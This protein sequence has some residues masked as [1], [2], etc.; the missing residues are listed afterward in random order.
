MYI[1]VNDV[2]M[3]FDKIEKKK[4]LIF[5]TRCNFVMACCEKNMIFDSMTQN[6]IWKMSYDDV[7]FYS[8]SLHKM[9]W[10]INILVIEK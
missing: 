6:K 10:I 1:M 7:A 2:K 5:F 8:T 4:F 9:N 3:F